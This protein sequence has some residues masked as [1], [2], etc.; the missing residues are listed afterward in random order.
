V[1]FSARLL[2]LPFGLL[3]FHPR[4]VQHGQGL[5]LRH[6]LAFAHQ[7]FAQDAAFQ[8]GNDLFAAIRHHTRALALA[9]MS[10]SDTEAQAMASQIATS[11]R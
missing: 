5:A 9:T 7:H 3:R 6:L 1:P 8:A 10:T 4:G 2:A 11:S